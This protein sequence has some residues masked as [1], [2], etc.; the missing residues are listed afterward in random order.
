MNNF[1]YQNIKNHY[2]H[3]QYLVDFILGGV[4]GLGLDICAIFCYAGFKIWKEQTKF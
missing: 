2:Y 4:L 1:Q 3:Y